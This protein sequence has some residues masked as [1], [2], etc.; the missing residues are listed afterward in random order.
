MNLES[1]LKNKKK[2]KE[3]VEENKI[4][5]YNERE[6]LSSMSLKMTGKQILELAKQDYIQYI[7]RG[8]EI[9]VYAV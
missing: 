7:T 3:F 2:L 5:V 6:Y 9:A 1:R 8:D 4:H